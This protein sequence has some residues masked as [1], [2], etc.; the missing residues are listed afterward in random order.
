MKDEEIEEKGNK[1]RADNMIQKEQRRIFD[2]Y[3]YMLCDMCCVGGSHKQHLMKF[4][5]QLAHLRKV[6]R[7]YDIGN[8]KRIVLEIWEP[9]SD[10]NLW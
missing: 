10:F 7:E 2:F 4:S 9:I 8:G 5:N 3:D 6:N 1:V